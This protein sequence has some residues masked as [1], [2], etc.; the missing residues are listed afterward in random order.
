MPISGE[1]HEAN[2]GDP[3]TADVDTKFW[4]KKLGLYFSGVIYNMDSEFLEEAMDL[5]D[6]PKPA[7]RLMHPG[8]EAISL[9][10]NHKTTD[11]DTEPWTRT[12]ISP[13]WS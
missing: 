3:I 4:E 5:W 8:K 9:L 10:N 7:D 13:R 1:K 6:D 12:Y 11:M 2:G